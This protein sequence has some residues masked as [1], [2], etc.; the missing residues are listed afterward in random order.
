MWVFNI[1]NHIKIDPWNGKWFF[2]T[3]NIESTSVATFPDTR[4]GIKMIKI[5][6]FCKILIKQQIRKRIMW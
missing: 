5:S 1:L 4:N 3:V 2:F 6:N